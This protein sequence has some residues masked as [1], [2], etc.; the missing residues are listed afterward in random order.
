MA[1]NIVIL[2]I[3]DESLISAVRTFVFLLLW[4]GR[5]LIKEIQVHVLCQGLP[6]SVR[7]YGMKGPYLQEAAP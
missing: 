4:S 2:H 1:R 6:E 7:V 3:F 5:K